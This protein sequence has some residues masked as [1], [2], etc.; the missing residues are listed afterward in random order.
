MV[1]HG[2]VNLKWYLLLQI[3]GLRITFG[4]DVV[5]RIARLGAFQLLL[6]NGLGARL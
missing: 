6:D 1:A 5:L 3:L 2:Q 4:R